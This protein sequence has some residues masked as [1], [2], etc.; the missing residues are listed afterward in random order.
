M[1][2]KKNTEI[3]DLIK[4]AMRIRDAAI[5]DH[6]GTEEEFAAD[7]ANY[8]S[9]AKL[10]KALIECRQ[11]GDEVSYYG[12]EFEDLANKIMEAMDTG[13]RT[14]I[15]D[16]LRSLVAQ[17]SALMISATDAE[18]HVLQ[19]V[20]RHML[21]ASLAI[22]GGE[23][24]HETPEPETPIYETLAP[25]E[26]LIISKDGD[27]LLVACNDGGELIVKRVQFGSKTEDAGRWDVED[28]YTD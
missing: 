26:C 24:S 20:R 16:E 9:D 18:S 2:N 28:Y 23:P 10:S 22:E 7:I 19:D 14:H 25:N 4:E 11:A 15:I 3:D 17:V 1:I 8:L 6:L 27:S 21:A 5:D 13:S 12:D